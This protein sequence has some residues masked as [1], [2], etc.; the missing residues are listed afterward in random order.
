MKIQVIDTLKLKSLSGYFSFA[1][2][3]QTIVTNKNVDLIST[4]IAFVSLSL[5]ICN[6]I[7]KYYRYLISSYKSIFT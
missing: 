6:N 1:I 2:V 3:T 4:Y 5:K 7:L